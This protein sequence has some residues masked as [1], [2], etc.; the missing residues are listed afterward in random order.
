MSA[1]RRDLRPR[2]GA[3]PRSSGPPR[4]RRGARAAPAPSRAAR[5]SARSTRGRRRAKNAAE[6]AEVVARVLRRR[7][8]PPARRGGGRSTSAISRVGTPS[9]RDAVQHRA[10][11]RRLQR[12]PEEARGV[13]AVDRRPAVGAV[14]DVRRRRPCA[15]AMSI[16]TGTK[17]WSPSPWTDGGS[18]TSDERTPRAASASVATSRRHAVPGVRARDRAASSSVATRPGA[19]SPIPGGDDERP[20]GAL[21]RRA[22]R[23]DGRAGRCGREPSSC[24]KSWM[25]A[26]WIDAVGRGGAAAQA[27][28]V[29]EVAAVDL[30]A[31]GRERRGGRVG[32]GEADDLVARARSARGR[33]RS[34]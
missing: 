3:P 19:S 9:S 1:R 14:A 20:V 11:R 25:N 29:V 33:R 26:Q 5:G 6:P 32:A 27:V 8:R 7:S 28:E 12:E 16:S 22:E 24:V 30:G 13:Q 4:G 18:R 17:P 10:G 34:R 15:R 23:L 2:P 31:G 21:E